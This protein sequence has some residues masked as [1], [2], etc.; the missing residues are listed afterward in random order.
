MQAVMFVG[1]NLLFRTSITLP[2]S[3]AAVYA[4][5]SVRGL[6][7]PASGHTH[8]GPSDARKAELERIES[9]VRKLTR[10][11]DS[12]D[13]EEEAKLKKKPKTSG[14]SLI[15]LQNAKY[16][17]GSAAA[18][19][20][21]RKKDESDILAT[22]SSFRGKLQNMR[23]D[24]PPAPPDEGMEVDQPQDAAGQTGR[25]EGRE[26]GGEEGL[27]V[28]DDVEWLRH[29]LQ[30]PKDSGEESA[31][32]ERDYEVI[33]PRARGARAKEEEKARKK[34]AK[35]NRRD[36]GRGYRPP[37]PRDRERDHGFE[38]W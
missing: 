34:D 9:E 25:E 26:G 5:A 19:R 23:S 21:G 28:D 3:T 37:P 12:D 16:K 27:E 31:R 20:Q 4:P 32:A 18:K 2:C 29:R 35:D 36:G 30:F 10:R 17:R 22:L 1:M 24:S 13:E 8:Y 33:D 6:L 11:R 7:P 14:P 38:R 15:E